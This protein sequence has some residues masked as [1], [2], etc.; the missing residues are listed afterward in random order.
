[1]RRRRPTRPVTGVGAIST[2]FALTFVWAFGCGRDDDGASASDRACATSLEHRRTLELIVRDDDGVCRGARIATA[3][4]HL[5]LED[6]PY[7]EEF[8]RREA[9]LLDDAALAQ[10]LRWWAQRRPESALDLA[11][12]VRR[13]RRGL[14]IGAVLEQ[15]AE[16]APEAAAA[17]LP[18][19]GNERALSHARAVAK[20]W[21][22]SKKPG[23]DA[24][25]SELPVGTIRQGTLALVLTR[26]TRRD[27]AAA[28]TR[29]VEA[30]PD[31]LPD[32]F[33]LQ[34]HRRAASAV[35]GLDVDYA[36]T[37]A[38]S[39]HDSEFGRGVKRIVATFWVIDDPEAAMAWL[40][41]IAD[42]EQRDPAVQEAYRALSG[43][44]PAAAMAW[45]EA[46]SYEPWM[47]PALGLYVVNLSRTDPQAALRRL[48]EIEDESR[49][50][51][52]TISVL[53]RWRATD[54]AAADAWMDQHSVSDE[55]RERVLLGA[56]PPPTEGPTRPSPRPRSP[57]ALGP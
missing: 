17:R 43:R 9:V 45:F 42:A 54:P 53:R 4:T 11:L 52:S 46:H 56:R 49:R 26:M 40:A 50:K 22:A 25:L 7:V 19:L 15:W 23:L 39:V 41:E 3:L 30:L 8:V 47:E 35:A 5:E 55:I 44:D 57:S 51:L 6:M 2:A 18:A 13:D 31:D 21:E 14:A 32:Q 33:K 20:G 38:D 28:A 27:G 10:V 48:S 24:F 36:R 16:D 1:M 12:E 29:W 34:A 37:W